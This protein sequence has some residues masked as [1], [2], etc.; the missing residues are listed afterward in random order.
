MTNIPPDNPNQAPPSAGI[1]GAQND[2]EL[3][4]AVSEPTNATPRLTP[5]TRSE[6]IWQVLVFQLKLTVDGLRDVILVPISLVA[7][8][9]GIVVGGSDPGKYFQRV[10][11]LGRRTEHWINLFGQRDS[12]GTSDEILSELQHQVFTRAEQ[13]PAINRANESFNKSL[14]DLS[15]SLT[16]SAANKSKPEPRTEADTDKTD[17]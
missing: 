13:N 3:P 15:A 16:K 12:S 7:A 2:I 9:I 6:V 1:D 11:K 8:L 14:D 5:Q 10:I 17:K 4:R